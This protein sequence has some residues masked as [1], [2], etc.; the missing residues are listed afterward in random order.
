M[1]RRP[2]RKTPRTRRTS[3]IALSL[4]GVLTPPLPPSAGVRSGDVEKTVARLGGLVPALV[5]KGS[6]AG[7][8]SLPGRRSVLAG[9]QSE[10]RY[11]RGRGIDDVFHVGIGGSSLGAETLLRAL[12]H[13]QHNQLP[14]KARSGPRVHFVDNVDPE[15]LAPLLEWVDLSKAMIHVVSKS[16]GTVETAAGFQ[17]LRRAFE[18]TGLA[19]PRHCVFT[20]GQGALRSLG[21]A[22]KIRMLDFPA[23]I[24][25][26]YSALTPSGLL[27]PAIAGI[28][29]A[30]VF[31]GAQRFALRARRV[32]PDANP[33]LVAAAVAWLMDT[34][35]AKPIHVL[36]PYAD[37]LEPLSRWYVQ[38]S[39]ESLGK[40]RGRGARA[41]HVGPTPLPARGTTDQHSQVQLFIE[42][43]ADKLVMFVST[44]RDRQTLSVPGLPPAEYLDGVELGALLR[45]ER[46]GTEV[47]LARAGRPSLCWEIPEVSP[48]A[49]GE[50]LVALQ[51]MTAAQAE[52][53]GID[54]YG[55]PGVEAGKVAAFAL[56]G[57]EGYED[58]AAAIEDGKPPT[59]RI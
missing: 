43:P 20:T 15:T 8:L 3:A 28:D 55:Q 44:A 30:G 19:W 26:R 36:M 48:G 17:I 29:V 21:A 9:V 51:L 59:W 50:L 46:A 47:A 56:L 11:W 13:P 23:D 16:G 5:S 54:A 24:G 37:A 34:R 4:G 25:G 39:G 6:P 42:G 22:E 49:V 38:L 41:R 7:F 32:A 10:A 14:A 58:E 45:A 52:L 2:A 35:R 33:A 12:A 27:T 1:T 18:T 31:A 40:I 53:Y 57:R